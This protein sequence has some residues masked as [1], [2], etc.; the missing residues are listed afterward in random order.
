[1]WWRRPFVALVIVAGVVD[2]LGDAMCGGAVLV[3]FLTSLGG[4]AETY[5]LLRVLWSFS[6][7]LGAWIAGHLVDRCDPALPLV[8]GVVGSALGYTLV[9]TVQTTPALGAVLSFT[10]L[11]DTSGVLVARTVA[12]NVPPPRR[13]S[14]FSLL[15]AFTAV[16]TTTVPFV[17]GLL[18]QHVS[19]RAPF[20]AMSGVSD[21]LAGIVLVYLLVKG[22]PRRR[23]V[24]S[25]ETDAMVADATHHAQLRYLVVALEVAFEGSAI[26]NN[27]SRA[28]LLK[29]VFALDVASTA[30]VVSS[31]GLL[32]AAMAVVASRVLARNS[33][34]RAHA[35]VMVW[36]PLFM[37]ASAM[38]RAVL[39][40]TRTAVALPL[41]V[42]SILLDCVAG[43]F[44]CAILDSLRVG[45]VSLSHVGRFRALV[46]T[47]V[48]GSNAGSILLCTFLY[49]R[50]ARLPYTGACLAALC[51]S[52]LG[53]L[54]V[55]CSPHPPAHSSSDTTDTPSE[56]LPESLSEL[57][58]DTPCS[59]SKG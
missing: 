23:D 27:T 21:V 12:M 56:S 32:D 55:R 43:N 29:D 47:C 18:A 39:V 30:L 46:K 34:P 4:T 1:M 37:F 28:F 25:S 50:N 57:T 52:L 3:F 35:R 36:A 45:V 59:T 53:R 42:L 38:L 6:K 8:L 19:L 22:P 10:S 24:G 7:M 51:T 40:G 17:G 58:S 14:V 41:F 15:S 49:R 31:E 2:S 11:F 16:S 26:L 33:S 20:W 44:V 5:G 13:A 9:A 48:M 54:L